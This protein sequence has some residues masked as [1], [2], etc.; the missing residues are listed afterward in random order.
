MKTIGLLA[1]CACVLVAPNVSAETYT[2][3]FA[4]ST[5]NLDTK[6][7]TT[8]PAMSA[9]QIVMPVGSPWVY[10]KEPVES[11]ADGK[12]VGSFTCWSKGAGVIIS[13]FCSPN[14]IASDAGHG[15][16]ASLNKAAT[17]Q[18]LVSCETVGY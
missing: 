3:T 18:L 5:Y 13:A 2:T 12:Y 10:R 16:V 17:I 1:L 11:R 9:G 15:A 8:Y 14:E 6:Q 4:F 7:V